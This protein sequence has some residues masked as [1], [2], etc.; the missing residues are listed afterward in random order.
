MES[1]GGARVVPCYQPC[2]FLVL[3]FFAEL[4]YRDVRQDYGLY[5]VRCDAVGDAVFLLGDVD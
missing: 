5:E 4:Y 3:L 1:V 2:Y